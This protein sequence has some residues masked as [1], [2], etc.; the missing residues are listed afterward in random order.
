MRHVMEP[1]GLRIYLEPDDDPDRLGDLVPE[2]WDFILPEEIGA[3]TSAPISSDDC[4]RTDEGELVRVGRIF[5]FPN[6]MIIDPIEA[7]R[8]PEGALFELA[9]AEA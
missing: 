9:E 5:W 1:R 2:S 4:E 8:T 6:Y 7:A 3:L